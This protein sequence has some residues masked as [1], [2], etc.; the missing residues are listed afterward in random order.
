ME[1][2]MKNCGY[3]GVQTDVWTRDHVVP[4][5][6]WGKGHL[7]DHAVIIPS[8][9]SC[10]LRFDVD[11]EYFRN[12]LIA[13]M[14]EGAHSVAD[15]LLS[16]TMKRSIERNRTV[17]ADLSRNPRVAFR[18][19]ESGII[20]A[21][22]VCVEFDR[23]RF[24]RIIEK[25]I[26]GIYFFKSR[27]VFPSGYQIDVYPGNDFWKDPVVGSLIN[28]MSPKLDFG[29]DVFAFHFLRDKED[30]NRIVWL[31]VFYGNMGILASTEILCPVTNLEQG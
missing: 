7:P 31:F 14:D 15:R 11:A 2:E 5:T 17:R 9:D 28:Q 25:I 27:V 6:L 4:S 16:S 22:G 1:K 3:C 23:P 13:M 10:R 20:V 21:G 8:C 24:N 19:T 30:P 26:R 12:C 29:D 18:K